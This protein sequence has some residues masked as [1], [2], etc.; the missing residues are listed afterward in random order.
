MQLHLGVNAT[1]QAAQ[2]L[3]EAGL[4]TY[5]RTDNPNLSDDGIQAVWALLRQRGQDAYIPDKPNSWKAKDGAQEAHE[6][7]RPTDF[8]LYKSADCAE[9]GVNAV[10]I[11]LYQLIWRRAVASQMKAARIQGAQRLRSPP[12]SQSPLLMP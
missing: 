11:Q 2:A 3:F 1:M 6:A 10:Q 9:R 7:I 5:H 8:N 12:P 4:I